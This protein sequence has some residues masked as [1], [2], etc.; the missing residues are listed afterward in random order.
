MTTTTA[1]MLEPGRT[2][3]MLELSMVL[4][5]SLCRPVYYAALMDCSLFC[6]I[7]R[8]T[9][10]AICGLCLP[11]FP[12]HKSISGLAACSPQIC[13][14]KMWSPAPAWSDASAAGLDDPDRIAIQSPG[15]DRIGLNLNFPIRLSNPGHEVSGKVH[16]GIGPSIQTVTVRSLEF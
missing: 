12:L 8:E 10:P 2:A 7:K 14:R 16:Y 11:Q 15:S 1:D 9:T 13:F 5:F 6:K 4:Y 3:D